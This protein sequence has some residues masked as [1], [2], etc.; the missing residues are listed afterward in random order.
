M[1]VRFYFIFYNKLEIEFQNYLV[2]L[3]SIE[4]T[5]QDT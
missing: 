1:F 3:H 5:G 2:T 4:V